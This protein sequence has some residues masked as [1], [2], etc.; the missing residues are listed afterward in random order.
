VGQP[1]T[2]LISDNGQNRR[3][4]VFLGIA[5]TRCF[6][7]F[8]TPQFNDIGGGVTEW[9]QITRPVIVIGVN[10]CEPLLGPGPTIHHF[11]RKC[12][13]T[14]EE[15]KQEFAWSWNFTTSTCEDPEGGGGSCPLFPLYP[16]EEGTAWDIVSCMCEYDPSPVLVDVAGN[17]FNLT[18]RSTGVRFDLNSDG[19][20]EELS[21]T[22]AGSDDA[23]LALDRNANGTIDNGA[24]L[25]GNF[26]SQPKP[27]VGQEKN[28]FL[29][30]AEYDKVSNGGNGDGVISEAD[31]ILVHCGYGEM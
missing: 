4:A 21:W 31:G 30:L 13:P 1:E 10:A 11:G 6:P 8:F 14:E 18:D 28:G 17:G 29:A 20:A 7:E 27:P 23:W 2:V 15:C 26:T 9:S 22:S 24:E 25:F 16:C 19:T 3:D 5:C 12:N